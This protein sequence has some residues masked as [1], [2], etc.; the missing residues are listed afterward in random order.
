MG[1]AKTLCHPPI[2][3]PWHRE[4]T[5]V[6]TDKLQ[7]LG[8]AQG[9][10][11]RRSP[12]QERLGGAQAIILQL[13]SFPTRLLQPLVLLS[14]QVP[15]PQPHHSALKEGARGG[16]A[17]PGKALEELG[18]GLGALGRPAPH[19]THTNKP[20]SQQ[21]RKGNAAASS[22]SQASEE[23]LTP[24]PLQPRGSSIAW[25]QREKGIHPK[26]KH[27]KAASLPP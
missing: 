7:N 1:A 23:D 11:W 14:Q 3:S 9:H 16:E 22:S 2:P 27:P 26:A 4:G 21:P 19:C 12:V 5:D 17:V 13:D 20:Q 18:Q 24:S 15:E 6:S 8:P 25:R 10:A